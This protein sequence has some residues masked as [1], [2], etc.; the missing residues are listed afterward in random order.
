[1]SSQKLVTNNAAAYKMWSR[2]QQQKP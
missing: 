2:S 1:M